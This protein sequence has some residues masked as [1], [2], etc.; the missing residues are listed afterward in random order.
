MTLFD[1]LKTKFNDRS[2]EIIK[3]LYLDNDC[4]EVEFDE[5]VNFWKE[6]SVSSVNRIVRLFGF[7]NWS[8]MK[9]SEHVGKF[10]NVGGSRVLI[11]ADWEGGLKN[12]RVL[13]DMAD[14][15]AYEYDKELV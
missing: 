8:D 5:I 10:Y 9:Q 2:I 1:K 4:T 3:Q 13:K 11:F 7:E 6:Y 15:F 12:R 14:V